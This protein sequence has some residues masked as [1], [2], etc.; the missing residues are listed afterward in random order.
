MIGQ[1]L[2]II[3]KEQIV[4]WLIAG[5]ALYKGK[6]FV[7]T[8]DGRLIALEASNA[9]VGVLTVDSTKPYTIT[10]TPGVVKEK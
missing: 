5:V 9:G 7:G 4:M 8:L 10:G 1:V 6:V 2:D 3:C